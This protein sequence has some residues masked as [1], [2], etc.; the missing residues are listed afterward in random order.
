MKMLDLRERYEKYELSFNVMKS[1]KSFDSNDPKAVVSRF[2]EHQPENVR[3]QG[4]IK[5]K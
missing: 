5:V 1:Y 3:L 4:E 2:L